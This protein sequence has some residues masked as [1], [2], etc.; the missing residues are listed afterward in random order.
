MG[1]PKCL[2]ENT[3]EL[4]IAFSGN[5]L[6]Y[7]SLAP[8]PRQGFKNHIICVSSA[9][10]VCQGWEFYTDRRTKQWSG[11]TGLYFFVTTGKV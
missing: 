10:E 2:P 4:F 11:R 8:I 1:I 6:L 9:R 3:V 7:V 5:I